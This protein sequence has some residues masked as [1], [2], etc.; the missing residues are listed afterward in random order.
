MIQEIIGKLASESL[1]S[2][3][4]SIVKNINIPFE[5]KL[6]TRFLPYTL[7]SLLFIDFKFVKENLF[8]KNGI[9]LSLITIIHIY[10]SYKGFEGLESG[11]AY[12]IFYLYP[13]MILMIA[14][15]KISPFMILP[16]VGVALLV[17]G[18]T[19]E[20]KDNEGSIENLEQ[21]DEKT[22]KKQEKQEKDVM[23][24]IIMIILA[25]FTEA[26]LYFIVR[27][28]K[29]PNNWNHLFISY[30]FGA[31]VLSGSVLNKINTVSLN[32]LLSSSFILNIVIGLFGYLL[33]FYAT[34]RL[35]PAIYAPLSYFGIVMS[36]VYGIIFNKDVI[37]MK[38]VIG[39]L[40][41]IIPNLY[42]SVK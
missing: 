40:L 7:V 2:L 6:W 36:Y 23:F 25:G 17:S 13:L 1:L 28:I 12:T 39:T 29:T 11:I 3:Y 21:K 15:E 34:T 10:T 9:L 30:A 35:E 32:G 8:S 27:K 37:T 20:S 41:V 31:M 14:G 4:P 18:N 33:R 24:S 19:E 16:L 26:L 42:I 22:P 5:M 38:K